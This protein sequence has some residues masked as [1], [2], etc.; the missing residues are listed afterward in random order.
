MVTSK[1]SEGKERKLLMTE[2]SKDRIIIIEDRI[3]IIEDSH[4][5][6][7][8]EKLSDNWDTLSTLQVM[9]VG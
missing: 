7:Y 8:A 1:I 5:R 2:Q 4:V 6:D 3:I 9:F